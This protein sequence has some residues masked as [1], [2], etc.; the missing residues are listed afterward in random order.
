M[1]VAFR[2]DHRME[3]HEIDATTDRLLTD[4]FWYSFANSPKRW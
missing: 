3:M 4:P 2:F 1:H